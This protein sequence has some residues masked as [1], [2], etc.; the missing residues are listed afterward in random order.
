LELTYGGQSKSATD[1]DKSKSATDGD[2]LESATDGDKSKSAADGDKLESATD[3]DKSKSATDGDKLE[4]ATDGDKSESAT[5]GD[6]LESATDG[7]K[8][9]SA[10][11]GDKSKSATDGDKSKSAMDDFG[12]QINKFIEY[13]KIATDTAL[14]DEL[15]DPRVPQLSSESEPTSKQDTKKLYGTVATNL[16]KGWGAIGDPLLFE[17]IPIKH[18]FQVFLLSASA[19]QHCV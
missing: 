17:A 1:G 15:S 13:V 18:F 12:E 11:D 19:C 10:T 3:G 14:R 16:R 2:K 7:D 8:S 6:K 5:D 9:K 4:S